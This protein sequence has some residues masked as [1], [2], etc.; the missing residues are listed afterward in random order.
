MSVVTDVEN[1]A[2]NQADAQGRD[3][4]H[5]FPEQF[6]TRTIFRLAGILPETALMLVHR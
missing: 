6:H 3:I 1:Q 5:V 2:D 4:E